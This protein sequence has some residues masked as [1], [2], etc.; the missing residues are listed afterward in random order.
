MFETIEQVHEI[1]DS[2]LSEY[3]EEQPH[4][5]LGRVPPLTFLPRPQTARESNC[6]LCR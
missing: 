5:S 2:W 4:D 1:T 3:N 6:K